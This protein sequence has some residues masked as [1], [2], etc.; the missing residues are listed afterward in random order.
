MIYRYGEN[1]EMRDGVF[2][3]V[4]P[5]IREGQT[6]SIMDLNPNVSPDQDS[7][8]LLWSHIEKSFILSCADSEFS[9]SDVKLI[10]ESLQKYSAQ[11]NEIFS[12][13]SDNL[14][15][16]LEDLF[17]KTKDPYRPDITGIKI[18]GFQD[19]KIF[20]EIG[21]D[22]AL[23]KNDSDLESHGSRTVPFADEA[24]QPLEQEVEQ[25]QQIDYV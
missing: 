25:E 24:P 18:D 16:D 17:Q 23:P 8:S 7:T 5:T 22:R 10:A 6:Y 2:R 11:I 15:Q 14:K 19:G 21:L 1:L 12:Q 20:G 3:K 13:I 9:Q 4:I